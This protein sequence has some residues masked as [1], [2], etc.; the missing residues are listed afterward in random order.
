MDSK[1]E[2]V[3]ETIGEIGTE[4][5][6]QT[7]SL[8]HI[9]ELKDFITWNNLFK[10][11]ISLVTLIIFYTLYRI[12]KHI[13][14]KRVAVKMEPHN[15]QMLS[16]SVSYIF[17][18]LMGMYILSL[19]GI[20]LKAIWGA[21]GVA[22]L[23]IGFAAQTSVSNI[24]SGLFVV[25]E[26]T[27]K[28]GDYIEVGGVAGT[29]DTIGLLSIKIHTADNQMI[30]IPN[31]TII[32]N[33]LINYSRFPKRRFVFEI[34]IGYDMDLKYVYNVVSKI[35]A[36]CKSVI[37]D[38]APLLFYDGFGDAIKLK[39]AVWFNNGDLFSVKTEVY[40]EIVKTCREENV[41][42]PFTH[43]D[44]TI[45]NDKGEKESLPKL[46]NSSA[47]KK[48]SASKKSAAK[49]V[50]G[51]KKRGPVSA[52]EKRAIEAGILSD[53]EDDEIK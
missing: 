6:E 15:A 26:K 11:A 32:N 20:D 40:T 39:L 23:A 7:K 28:I 42:I 43:Y 14:K 2:A 51:R 47:S 37:K 36:K 10:V 22:G 13:L 50:A 35:P 44:I 49:N 25:S 9:D 46:E 48:T 4:V 1:K 45:L 18:I 12:L 33:N 30:R 24:I 34:P 21:A 16:K 27:L 52:A 19:F 29:V 38:P 41:T 31:S 8:F 5:T 3:V 17:Y 53:M